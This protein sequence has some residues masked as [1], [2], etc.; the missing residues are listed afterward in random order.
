MGGVIVVAIVVVAAIFDEVGIPARPCTR[1]AGGRSSR[2]LPGRGNDHHD[3]DTDN[4]G[5]DYNDTDNDRGDDR[6][7]VARDLR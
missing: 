3:D 1:C 2:D 6:N 5:G 7:L 4:G